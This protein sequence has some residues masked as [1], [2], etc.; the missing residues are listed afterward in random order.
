MRGNY[1][2]PEETTDDFERGTHENEG[3]TEGTHPNTRVRKGFEWAIL[4]TTH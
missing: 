4:N 2:A 1:E 3:V